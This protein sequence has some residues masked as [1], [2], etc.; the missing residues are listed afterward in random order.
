MTKYLLMNWYNTGSSQKTEKELTS[1]AK[2]VIGAL[3]FLLQDLGNFD[4]HR[5]NK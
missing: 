4:A 2:E 1:L 3:Q 5:E